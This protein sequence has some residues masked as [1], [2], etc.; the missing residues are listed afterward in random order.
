MD[1][2][3]PELII[4][5]LFH[6]P[7]PSPTLIDCPAPPVAFIIVPVFVRVPPVPVSPPFWGKSTTLDDATVDLRVP[8][9]VIVGLIAPFAS[10]ATW[11][12]VSIVPVA[13]FVIT[14]FVVS[15][16]STAFCPVLLEIVPE[17]V[18]VTDVESSAK[19]AQPSA[20]IVPEFSI[21]IFWAFLRNY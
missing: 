15:F 7:S 16:I 6:G 18:I 4:F 3:V 5:K 12:A 17:F 1:E 11:V 8:W 20:E 10:I 14:A 21:V 13:V 19:I 9:L 2:I